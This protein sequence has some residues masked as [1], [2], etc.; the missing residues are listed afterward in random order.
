MCL[1]FPVKNDLNIFPIE[2]FLIVAPRI[3]NV[4]EKH[5][6]GEVYKG[7]IINGYGESPSI[8]TYIRGYY[9]YL[10]LD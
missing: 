9:T 7:F 4:S 1:T 5:T 3:L 10:L 2:S 8:Y 6:K